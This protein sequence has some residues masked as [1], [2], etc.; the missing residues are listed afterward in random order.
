[1]QEI[2]ISTKKNKASDICS[3]L[4]KCTTSKKRTS[5]TCYPLPIGNIELPTAQY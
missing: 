2:S 5:T 3:D 4:P 1:M